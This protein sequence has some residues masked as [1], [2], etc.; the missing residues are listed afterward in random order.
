LAEI[1]NQQQLA[2]KPEKKS[3]I[4]YESDDDKFLMQKVTKDKDGVPIPGGN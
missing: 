4:N 2:I 1:K 3:E